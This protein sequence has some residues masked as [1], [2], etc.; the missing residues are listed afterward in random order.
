MDIKSQ[1]FYQRSESISTYGNVALFSPLVLSLILVYSFG[2]IGKILLIS[3]SFAFAAIFSVLVYE[4]L[5]GRRKGILMVSSISAIY[6]L[7]ATLTLADMSH[8][9]PM[10]KVDTVAQLLLLFDTSVIASGKVSLSAGVHFLLISSL[11]ALMGLVISVLYI[12]TNS[13]ENK[14]ERKCS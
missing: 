8:N 13:E 1:Q 4:L 14:K 6:I 9:D 7:F 2:V 10:L 3:I 5:A 12:S 11:L